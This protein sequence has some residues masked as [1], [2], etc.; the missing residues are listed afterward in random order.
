MSELNAEILPANGTTSRTGLLICASA[1]RPSTNW[2]TGSFR[3][4]YATK[5]HPLEGPSAYAYTPTEIDY[6]IHEFDR[7]WIKTGELISDIAKDQHRSP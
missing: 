6:F 1:T 4:Y 2:A 3:S 7:L 5:K